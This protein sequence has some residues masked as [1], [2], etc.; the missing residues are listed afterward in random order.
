MATNSSTLA[1]KIPLTE[2][3]SEHG[4]SRVGHDLA[5]KPP[6]IS[7]IVITKY[8]LYSLYYTIYPYSLLC[9]GFQNLFIFGC[10]ESVAAQAFL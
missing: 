9:F 2:E 5:T 7:P 3:P 6:H 4:V 10:A 1:W 8:W